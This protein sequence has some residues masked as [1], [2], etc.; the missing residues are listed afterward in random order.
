MTN[1][2]LTAAAVAIGIAVGA[3]LGGYFG[4]QR[5]YADGEWAGR[6]NGMDVTFKLMGFERKP[7]GEIEVMQSPRTLKEMR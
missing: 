5:G 2:K 3:A 4:Y 6:G 7:A 1:G